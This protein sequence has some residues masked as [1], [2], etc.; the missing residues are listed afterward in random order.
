MLSRQL[1]NQSR[2]HFATATRMRVNPS[3]ARQTIEQN[4]KKVFESTKQNMKKSKD[5]AEE[6]VSMP[7][8]QYIKQFAYGC[9]IAGVVV[10]GVAGPYLEYK[11]NKD[12]YHTQTTT[13]ILTQSIFTVPKGMALGGL[14]GFAGT[15]IT[16]YTLSLAYSLSPAIPY[17]AAGCGIIALFSLPTVI[18]VKLI[19]D[20]VCVCRM[21]NK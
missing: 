10:G 18:Y 11:D 1:V 15:G 19:D 5:T 13:E 21:C 14:F 16:G 9:G 8:E 2:R 6:P 4:T 17:V 7:G 12:H 20:D 3:Q